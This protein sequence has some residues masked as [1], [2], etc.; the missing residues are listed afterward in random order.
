MTPDAAHITIRNTFYSISLGVTLHLI[1]SEVHSFLARYNRLCMKSLPSPNFDHCTLQNIWYTKR[2][3]V[4]TAPQ[5]YLLRTVCSCYSD[6]DTLIGTSISWL[7]FTVNSKDCLRVCDVYQVFCDGRTAVNFH[8][9]TSVNVT[10][11]GY[12]VTKRSYL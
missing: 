9:V 11:R 1:G 10:H 3:K 4:L 6:K 8:E 12:H 2:E 7:D 5:S